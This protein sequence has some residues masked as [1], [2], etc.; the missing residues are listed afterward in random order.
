MSKRI[1]KALAVLA[2]V[3]VAGCSSGVAEDDA[4][5]GPPLEAT[6]TF[7]T[8]RDSGALASPVFE[9][10]GRDVKFEFTQKPAK[11]Y[12]SSDIKTSEVFLVSTDPRYGRE[13][14]NALKRNEDAFETGDD[15]LLFSLNLGDRGSAETIEKVEKG[16]PP[17][18][19]VG[20]YR[21]FVQ[22]DH[23]IVSAKVTELD[24]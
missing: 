22:T 7:T 9:L 15:A 4:P 12:E 23:G 1:S 2:F 14:Y 17:F 3:T 20:K 24:R 13:S 5:Q 16:N 21:L 6:Y 18:D 10:S 11:G 8:L 19:N